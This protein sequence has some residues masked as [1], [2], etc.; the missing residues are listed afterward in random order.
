M[1]I[2]SNQ[3]AEFY[4]IVFGSF[5]QGHYKFGDFGG[6]QCSA[7][8]L[9]SQ[10]FSI[11][12]NVAY[13]KSDDLDSLLEHGTDLYK[14]I[15]KDEYLA[16]EDLP[17]VVK[18]F[19]EPVDVSFGFNSHGIL[20]WDKFNQNIL[21]DF[22]CSNIELAEN[23]L[24]TG[25]L[26]WLSDFT[27]SVVVKQAQCGPDGRRKIC[28]LA[29]L[30]SHGRD[31]NGRISCGEVSVLMFFKGPE[32]FI[33]Y[34]CN[35]YLR[36]HDPEHLSAYQ[37]QFVKCSCLISQE[38]RRKIVRLH[39]SSSFLLSEKEEESA[40]E[41]QILKDHQDSQKKR[42]HSYLERSNETRAERLVRLKK[43]RENYHL[44][45]A[46]ETASEK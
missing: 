23:V 30:D 24:N 19:A 27:I 18:I 22:I 15:G 9:Y 6:R 40:R 2:K 21:K 44:W 31:S 17:S 25:F 32:S 16:R 4:Q 14:R 42:K 39:K 5:N 38:N 37:I 45:R 12:K 7:I 1:E 3:R 35:A 26:L 29:V 41:R 33:E 46:S 8:A 10:A 20:S 34:L 11:I 13:W 36:E 43:M 28:Q